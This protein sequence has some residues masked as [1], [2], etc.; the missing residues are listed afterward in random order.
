M[1]GD[2]VI[3]RLRCIVK[4]TN[5]WR[6]GVNS[7]FSVIPYLSVCLSLCLSVCLSVLS[8]FYPITPLLR[9]LVGPVKNRIFSNPAT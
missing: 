2:G 4:S 3:G 5:F 6:D 8:W 7:Y 9:I 1:V